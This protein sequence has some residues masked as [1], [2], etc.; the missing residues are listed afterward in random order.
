MTGELRVD[1]AHVRDLSGRQSDAATQ[2]AAATE[3]AQGVS[4]SMFVNHGIACSA[5][6]AAVLAAEMARKAAGTRM[7]V[8]STEL[9]QKLNIAAERY[10]KTDAQAAA[11]INAQMHPR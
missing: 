10:D 9:S 1:T 6:N 5:A 8:E 4:S 3:V 7:Q 11:S 2:I